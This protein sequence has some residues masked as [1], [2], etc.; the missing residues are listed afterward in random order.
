M[1][2]VDLGGRPLTLTCVSLALER[3]GRG[4]ATRLL[5]H[6]LGA[7]ATTGM[8]WSL[9]HS[10]PMNAPLYASN[11]WA[12]TTTKYVTIDAPLAAGSGTVRSVR[13]DDEDELRRLRE[14]HEAYSGAFVGACHAEGAPID[15][16]ATHAGR[17]HYC[18]VAQG[19]SS[20]PLSTGACG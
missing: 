17:H 19:A 10:S 11:G 9:L 5:Q 1:L 8:T 18:L 12:M 16:A 13:W 4:Y 7:M 14:L 15:Y 6:A 20:A 3:R 2:R